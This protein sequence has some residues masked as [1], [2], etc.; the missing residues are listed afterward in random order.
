MNT[1]EAYAITIRGYL[2]TDWE[3]WFEGMKI[4]T[5]PHK[6]ETVLQGTIVDQAQLFGLLIKIRNLGLT[7]IDVRNLNKK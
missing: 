4:S 6:N 1:P 7:L 5:N 2:P 3:D